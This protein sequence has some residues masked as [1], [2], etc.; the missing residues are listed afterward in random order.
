MLKDKGVREFVQAAFLLKDQL[1]G[2]VVFRLVGGID[3]ENPAALTESEIRSMVVDDYLIWEGHRTDIK[4]VYQ[5]SHIACLPSYREGMPKSLIEAMA[6]SCAI[7]TTDAPGC[8]EC[9]DE[10]VNGFLVPVG[11]SVLLAKRILELVNNLEMLEA[12]GRASRAKMVKSMSLS[13]VI[14]QTFALYEA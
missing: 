6:M 12:M 8:R 2:K 14:E 4:T 11:D 3:L 7:I 13:R 10:G 1:F 5:N 9:V